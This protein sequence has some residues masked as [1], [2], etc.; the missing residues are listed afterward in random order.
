MGWLEIL[1]A[2]AIVVEIVFTLQVYSNF[3]YAMK[4]YRR[5]RSF[6][7]PCVLIVPCKGLVE[8][9]EANIRSFYEQEYKRYRLWFVVA[10]RSDPAYEALLRLKARHRRQ[11]SAQEVRILTAGQT[12]GC[13]Q[14]LHNLLVAY[15]Q[16]PAEVEALVFADSDACAGPDWLGQLVAPLRKRHIGLASGYRWF[17]PKENNWATL[18]L[19]AMNAKVCQ[20]LGN[21]RFNLAW[22]GSMSVRKADF[23]RLGVEQIWEH[24][25][26]DDLS[27]SRAVRKAG[28]RTRFV[29]ACMIASYESTTW[30]KLWEFSRR[31]FIITRV[32]SPRLWLFG[33][34]GALL[35]VAGLWGGLGLAAWGLAAR[36]RFWVEYA[37]VG[38]V[39]LGCQIFRAFLRQELAARLLP[40]DKTAMRSARWAD[41]LGFWAWGILLLA[42]IAASAAGR[43]I[44]WRGI[45]YRLNGPGDIEILDAKYKQ[46]TPAC[47]GS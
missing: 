23:V 12:S 40:K 39:F 28:L 33:L 34:F 11:S 19:S 25:L 35:S 13:S 32:Y 20:L 6:Q 24:S 26:S 17:V 9:F 27:L 43:T 29:P 30:A 14:K 36:P 21:T 44:V 37:A 7:P 5:Q 18:A 15:R 31:Q 8:A 3:H 22:G 16:T 45:R 10:D 42:V 41:R 2:I 4:K 47:T 1:I 46:D 38:A